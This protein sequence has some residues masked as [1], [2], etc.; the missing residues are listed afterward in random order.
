MTHELHIIPVTLINYK[1]GVLKILS[2]W[3]S[4]LYLLYSFEQ[5]RNVV[6]LR[7]RDSEFLRRI[8]SSPV[9]EAVLEY[10]QNSR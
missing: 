2:C 4:V 10:K 5:Q 3:D 8:M 9:S 1:K 7:T 6:I